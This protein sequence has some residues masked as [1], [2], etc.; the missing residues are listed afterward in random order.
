MSETYVVITSKTEGLCS[1]NFNIGDKVKKIPH[2]HALSDTCYESGDDLYTNGE[3][4]QLM[5]PTDVEKLD[6]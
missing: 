5:A 3:F 1:H 2:P 4:I 6:E